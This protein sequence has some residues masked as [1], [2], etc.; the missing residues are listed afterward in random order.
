MLKIEVDSQLELM[1]LVQPEESLEWQAQVEGAYTGWHDVESSDHLVGVVKMIAGDGDWLT[2]QTKGLDQLRVGRYAQT[3]NTGTGYQLEVAR[4]DGGTTYNW[5]IGLGAAAADA[6][7]EPY[8]A[9]VSSQDLGLAAVI[10]VLVS[11]LRGQGL[12]LGY[13]AALRIYR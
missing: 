6:G 13:G 3:M 1:L 11:W 10:E 5:R 8:A 4:A 9:A 12:P 7:N 2:V